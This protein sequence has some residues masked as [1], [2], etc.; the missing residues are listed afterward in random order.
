M[1]KLIIALI[2][3]A[4]CGTVQ[5]EEVKQQ[6]FLVVYTVQY[7]AITLEEAAK[8]EQAFR[9]TYKDAC[10]VEIEVREKVISDIW[11]TLTFIGEG[12]HSL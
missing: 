1:K 9:T 8:K 12:E 7:N 2:I 10:K 5:A 11:G 6:K 4:F 3:M